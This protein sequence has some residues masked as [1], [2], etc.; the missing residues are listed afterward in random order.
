MHRQGVSP[1][2]MLLGQVNTLCFPHICAVEKLL[3][4]VFK[5]LGPNKSILL[6]NIYSDQ[7][8]FSYPGLILNN[9]PKNIR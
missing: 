2:A 9:K 6:G 8:S 5:Y 4:N 1:T 7:N 3:Q